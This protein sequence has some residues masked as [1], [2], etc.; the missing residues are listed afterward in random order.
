MGMILPPCAALARCGAANRIVRIGGVS[1]TARRVIL[2]TTAAILVAGA[3]VLIS[4]R[5][6]LPPAACSIPA[7]LSPESRRRSVASID[8]SRARA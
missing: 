1:A 2:W 8:P 7:A 6:P 5:H 3:V 4:R